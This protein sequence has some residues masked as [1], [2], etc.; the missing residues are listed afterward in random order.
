[1]VIGEFYDELNLLSGNPLYSM[2]HNEYVYPF[3]PSFKVT[4][5]RKAR[6][7]QKY[8]AHLFAK[9]EKQMVR[10]IA[11]GDTFKETFPKQIT[12]FVFY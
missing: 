1:M 10:F 12:C 8:A 11:N 7:L 6:I 3:L 2:T 9:A 4:W 5:Q